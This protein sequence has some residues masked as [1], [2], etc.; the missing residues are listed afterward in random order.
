MPSLAAL[1]EWATRPW[2]AFASMAAGVALGEAA[3]GLA[4]PLG[5]IGEFYIDLLKMMVL[6]FMVAAVI[7][8]LQRL[9]GDRR[10]LAILPRLLA[11]FFLAFTAAALA[12]ILAGSLVAPGRDLPLATL[13]SMGRLAGTGAL[14]G[15]H[16][17]VTLFS[18]GR[19]VHADGLAELAAALIPSNIFTALTRGETLKVM[20]F[21][22]LFGLAAGTDPGRGRPLKDVLETVYQACL[23]LTRWFNR[24][25]S[26]VLFAIMASLTARTGLEPLKAMARFI[27]ALSLGALLLLLLALVALALASRRPWR[28]VLRCQRE[29][30]LMA[31]ATRTS[32]ACMPAMISSLVDALGF[33][34]GRIELLVP[35][36]LSLL[37]CG[38]TL[39]YVVATLF[40]AQ[41][42]DVQLGLGKLAV[43][44]GGSIL[45]GFAS[46]GSTGV[47]ALSLTSLLCGYLRLP[48]EGALALF[49]AVDPVCDMLRTTVGVIGNNAFAAVAAGRQAPGGA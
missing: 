11:T 16:D 30:A 40:L 47:V 37:R 24:G 33:S 28:E 49:I 9:F 32:Q 38:Q 8:S 45:I 3:P 25:L 46:A 7:F 15:Y 35:L 41:L 12:G 36:G 19:E 5:V 22:M 4:R 17:T 44:F 43:V 31:A 14:G 42:Y 2:V 23:L 21:S 6:P 39:Y 13:A 20:V 1:G 10:S 26:L 34:R 18:A 27:L 29:P 48:F